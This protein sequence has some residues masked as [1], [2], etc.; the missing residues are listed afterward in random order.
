[1]FKWHDRGGL[2]A[3][4]PGPGGQCRGVLKPDV[5]FFGENVPRDRVAE[6]FALTETA[7]LLL[8]LGSSLTVQSGYR[9]VRRATGLG[10]PVAIINQ[11]PTRGDAE[12]TLTLDAPLGPALTA[13]EQ[14]PRPAARPRPIPPAR[15]A[16]PQ[17]IKGISIFVDCWYS[18]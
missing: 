18:G 17:K 7:S 14:A 15:A 11:G 6:C 16:R 13:Q 4:G 10:I 3:T 1:M 2:L 12:A 9:F 5:I 8:V